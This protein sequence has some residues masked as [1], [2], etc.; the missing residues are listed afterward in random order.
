MKAKG[1]H[2]NPKFCLGKAPAKVDPR[3]LMLRDIMR[4]LPPIPDKWFIDTNKPLMSLKIPTPIFGNDVYGD[5]VMAGRAHQT[6]RFEGYEQGKVIPISDKE[7]EAEY[8]KESGGQDNGLVMLDSLNE[9]RQKGWTAA[10]KNYTIDAYGSINVQD[11]KMVKAAMYLLN[12]LYIGLQLPLSA[13]S[14][15]QS[16][17]HWYDIGGAD[18]VPGT[19]GGHCVYLCAYFKEG[20]QCVTWG[21]KWWMSW[22][23]LE[24][25]CDEIYAVVDNKDKWLGSN[26]P[27]D[28]PKLEQYLKEVTS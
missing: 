15:L 10:R 22:Y 8:F 13:Y 20:V 11:L 3:T 21:M 1:I 23:F 26:S 5:C 7:V 28:I 27:L 17:S 4:V 19:W 16:A 24:K 14:Q 25:Y 18:G 6:L 9:W 12:G 2:T